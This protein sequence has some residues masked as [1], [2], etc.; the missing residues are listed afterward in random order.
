MW[1]DENRTPEEE[2]LLG[3]ARDE[4]KAHEHQPEQELPPPPPD[5]TALLYVAGER[6]VFKCI[7]FFCLLYLPIG[8]K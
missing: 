7:A 3:G 8:D 1:Q 2:A 4:R 5:C 6:A